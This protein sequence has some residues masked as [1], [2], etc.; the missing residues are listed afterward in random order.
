[1]RKK[2]RVVSRRQPDPSLKLYGPNQLQ[3]EL[4]RYKNILVFHMDLR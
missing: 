4:K 2:F 1:M 3:G